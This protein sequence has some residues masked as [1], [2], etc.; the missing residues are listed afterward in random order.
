MT[1]GHE[2]PDPVVEA[3]AKA[4][5][6]DPKPDP[7]KDLKD[8]LEELLEK[9]RARALEAS[10]AAADV[11]DLEE[12][13][14]TLRSLLDSF[15]DSVSDYDEAIAGLQK[16]RADLDAYR[17]RKGPAIRKQAHGRKDAYDG[18]I[19]DLMNKRSVLE[20]RKE[21]AEP[22]VEKATKAVAKA[23][24]KLEGAT[25]ALE[26]LREWPAALSACLDAAEAHR[27]A[28][29]SA[30]DEG[31]VGRMYYHFKHNLKPELDCNED[32]KVISPD[33]LETKLHDAWKCLED[34]SKAKREADNALTAAQVE[35]KAATDDLAA[36]NETFEQ[37]IAAELDEVD[38][39][40]IDETEE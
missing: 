11:S 15:A 10:Q 34:K 21:L 8:D 4:H 1:T 33:E 39:A 38:E 19:E 17:E 2:S 35:L 28:I 16:R 13:E 20:G 14:K 24:E 30:D 5:E 7:E 31:Q 37:Q 3:E 36:L 26:R 23:S 40:P 29:E 32:C 27:A 22:E 9:I 25:R 18:V 6:P 12:Q